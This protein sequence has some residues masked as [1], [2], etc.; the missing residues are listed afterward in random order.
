MSNTAQPKPARV[1]VQAENIPERVRRLKRW[2]VW[3]WQPRNGKWDKPP[4]QPD[5]TF[6]R[7][8]DPSTWVTFDEALEAHRAGGID[9]IGFVLGYDREEDVTYSGID[10]DDCRDPETGDIA[11]WATAH[12]QTI[13]TYSEVSPSGAGV[14]ALAIGGLPGRDRNESERL[15]VEVYSGG[16]YF[17]VTG[18]RLPASPPDIAERTAEL[19]DLYYQVFGGQEKQATSG[20]SYERLDDR[21]LAI[22]ALAGLSSSLA[23]GYLDWLRVGMALHAVADDRSMLD[24]WDAWSRNCA[25]K[26]QPGVCESKWRTF[27]KKGGLGLGSLIHW[28]RQNGWEF[29]R[30]GR[31][32]ESSAKADAPVLDRLG[33]V[34]AEGAEA[35]FRD[36]ALLEA[37]ARLA[38]SDPAEFACVRAKVKAAGVSLRDLDAVLT[39]SRQKVR[40]QRPRPESAGAYRVAGGRIVHNRV[41]R[42]GP[43]EVPLCNFSARIAEVVSRDDGVERSAVFTIEGSLADGRTLPALS[44]PATEFQRLEWVTTGWHGEAVVFA[45]SGTRDHTRCAIELLSRD[46]S[47][48]LQYLHTG[49]REVGGRWVFL[50]AGGAIGGDGLVTGVEVDLAGALGL[51]QLPEPPAGGDLVRAVRASL[52]IL[53]AGPDRVTFPLL[54]AVYRTPLGDVDFSLHQVGASGVFKSELAA[55]AQRH[56]GR[57]FDARNLPGSWSSTEN[58]L[59]ELAFAAKDVLV[60]VDDFKPGGTSYDVQSYH[61][62]ADRLFRA[63]GNHAGR[64]RMSRDGRLR[65]DRRPRGLVLSTGEEIPR[66]ESLRARLFILD[67]ARGDVDLPRLTLCQRDADNGQYAASMSAYLTWLAPRYPDIRSGLRGQRDALRSQVGVAGGHARSARIVADLTL[68]MNHFLDF[69]LAV[70]AIDSQEQAVV[71][72]RCW[73]ALREAAA[74]QVGHVGASEPT[75]LF[76]RLLSAALASG[77]GH[78]AGPDGGEPVNPG[79]WGWRQTR[80]G[81]SEFERQEWRPYGQRLGWVE[82]VGKVGLVGSENVYLQLDACVAAVEE[83]GQR[84]G[85]SPG[86]SPRTLR[87]R[88]RDRGLLAS[89]DEKREVLTVRRTLEGCRREV[90]HVRADCLFCGPDQP[91]QALESA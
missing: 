4:L 41:T 50:H 14:K 89:V 53:A 91:D 67:V 62:K 1:E 7:T 18:Q 22:S 6:A 59:E 21:E 44:V 76:L 26:Y 5:G 54:G 86:L 81:N 83:L 71:S 63:V 40:S 65:P 19:A 48:R 3:N 30:P 20:V 10:L 78:L 13:D 58:A 17:T 52:D 37:L 84:Q 2:V 39:P 33:E 28:A 23:T 55:L 66:G 27:G 87:Q 9:G 79:A 80:V 24:A 68:G 36:S 46:R 69:A 34:R 75:A 74:A 73:E 90:V 57:W 42:E 38:E 61:R 43:V 64:Q 77:R 25:E 51:V 15:G 45:G 49:W 32:A 35:L 72:R 31:K 16:R 47:R 60:V 82:P 88:L 85:E 8:D 12:L 70:G 56:Y 11:E 29:P